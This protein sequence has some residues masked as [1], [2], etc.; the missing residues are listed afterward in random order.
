MDFSLTDDQQLLK[1]TARTLLT[2]ECPTSLV[3]AHMDDPSVADT[4]WGELAGWTE[5]GDGPLVDLCLF[6]EEAG[7]VLLP[8]PFFAT[9]ALYR[10]LLAAAGVDPGDGPGTVA[11][12][13]ASGEWEVS[14]DPVR[15]FVLDAD[16]VEKVAV[17]LPGPRVVVT[18]PA[19]VRPIELIDSTRRV[20]EIDVPADTSGAVDVAPDALAG[21]LERATV[22]MAADMVGTARRLL[23]LSVEYAKERVQF[24]VP[25]GSFQAVQHKLADMALDVER[26]TAAVYYAAMTIDAD[27]PDRHRAAHA[28][29]AAA[30]D[31]A[32][33]AA[34]DGVQTH[35]GIG[36]TW[37][38]DLHLFIR[39]AYASEHLLGTT[40]WHRDRLADLLFD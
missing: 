33:R 11:L 15:T 21:V 38:H 25:I 40:D 3:R 17:V 5:L 34:K 29:K 37:E 39:R 32:R 31:A 22:A 14:D 20:F 9:A 1:D 35:G 8:G 2:K 28:A 27:D 36:Y 4:L 26:A 12:A 10:P 16:R 7:A 6:L 13:G 18:D 23:E 30:G 24:D 19:A